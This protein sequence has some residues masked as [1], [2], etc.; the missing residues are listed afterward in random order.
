MTAF[1]GAVAVLAGLVFGSFFNVCI[2]RI[3]RGMSIVWPPS[4]C[5]RCRRPVRWF[6]NIPVV[7]WI[8]LRGRCRDCGQKFS[9]RY[10][11]VE[12]L[13]GLL[14]LAA[15]LRFGRSLLTLK[16]VVF[17]SLLVVI[18]FIDIDH[19][20]I[21]FKLSIPGLIAGV[22]LSVIAGTRLSDVL[23]GIALGAGFVLGAWLLWRYWLAGAFQKFGVKQREGIGWGDLPFAMMVG[24]FVGLKPMVVAVFSAVVAG[25]IVGMAGRLAG[26]TRPGQP[27]SFGPFLGLGG[28][29]GLFFGEQLFGLYLRLVLG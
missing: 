7:S 29:V 14:F 8:V 21:P 1:L 24:A 15:Y 3:P 27:I 25:V 4:H 2:W 22:F 20:V 18:S 5:I 12:L 23:S 16:A 19:Q 9:S 10:A 28:I 6:D 17:L 26:K 11:L 13:T